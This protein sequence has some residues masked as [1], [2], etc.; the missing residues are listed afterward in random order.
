MQLGPSCKTYLGIASG[1]DETRQPPFLGLAYPR[2]NIVPA[3]CCNDGGQFNMQPAKS[4]ALTSKLYQR[5]TRETQLVFHRLSYVELLLLRHYYMWWPKH[6]Q[7]LRIGEEFAEVF[8]E[9]VLTVETQPLIISY[10]H[11]S[12]CIFEM[13]LDI[14]KSDDPKFI[15]LLCIQVAAILCFL[16][17]D[18][19]V[20]LER[21]F[22]RRS[23][24]LLLGNRYGCSGIHCVSCVFA[25]FIKAI[26]SASG[27]IAQPYS[28]PGRGQVFG[29]SFG[30]IVSL[31][32]LRVTSDPHH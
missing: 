5:P 9:G 1:E 10:Q 3:A 25:F 32:K 26:V 14:T 28:E 23:H 2:S 19:K 29:L 12:V 18:L 6:M 11:L 8:D 22:P 20:C 17:R 31:I 27:K 4:F 21:E 15:R 30:P 13:E 7:C 16:V 24:V